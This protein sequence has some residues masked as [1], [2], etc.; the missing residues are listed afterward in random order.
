MGIRSPTFATTL[1]LVV[2]CVAGQA[3]QLNADLLAA[4]MAGDTASAETA[5]AAGA[6]IEAVNDWKETALL[7]ACE[8]SHE[9]T[10]EMLINK[11]ANIEARN[12]HTS[13]P[14]MRAALKGE[15]DVVKLL[16]AKGANVNAAN[17]AGITALSYASHLK[18]SNAELSKQM[19][20]DLA[21][22]GAKRGD[23]QNRAHLGEMH[24]A[25][26]T[27]LRRQN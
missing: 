5:L 11:G 25:S 10:A 2:A 20:T 13:T 23:M 3:A 24:V 27:D 8:H 26:K 1:L 6:S 9:E 7:V 15:H 14:I 17:R 4:A 19:M 12:N 22:A 16:I 18:G 21:A